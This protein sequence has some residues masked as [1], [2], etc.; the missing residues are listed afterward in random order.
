MCRYM[1]YISSAVILFFNLESSKGQ[2]WAC[3]LTKAYFV[4]LPLPPSPSP[5][6]YL[7]PPRLLFESD[8][9]IIIHTK[10]TAFLSRPILLT[11]RRLNQVKISRW[12]TTRRKSL[13]HIELQDT[14]L[15]RYFGVLNFHISFTEERGHKSVC[16]SDIYSWFGLSSRGL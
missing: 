5:P 2:R 11:H 3:K 15:C 13:A 7:P 9:D 8:E 10:W 1:S 6:H 4:P 16:T 12:R 14:E